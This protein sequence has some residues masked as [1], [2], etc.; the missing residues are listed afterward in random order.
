MGKYSLGYLVRYTS[1]AYIY[2]N[3]IEHTEAVRCFYFDTGVNILVL[4]K[5]KCEILSLYRL[6]FDMEL[7]AMFI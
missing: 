4:F 3:P 2:S 5:C 7:I 6:L 1:Y